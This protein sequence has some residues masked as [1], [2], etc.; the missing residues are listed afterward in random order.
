MLCQVDTPDVTTSLP[1]TLVPPV[2]LARLLGEARVASGESLDDLVR[3]SGLAFEEE[4]FAD[5]ESGRASLDEPLVRWLAELY[6]VQA[7]AIVPA[8]SQLIIDLNEG[9]VAVGDTNVDL[10]DRD[11]AHILTNYLAL[12]YSLRGLPVGTPIPLRQV[13]LSALS[14]AL[15]LAPREVSSALGH[16]MIS[17]TDHVRDHARSLR[18]RLVVPVAGILVGLTAV[19][20]LLLVRSEGA[21][22]AHPVAPSSAST[23]TAAAEIPVQIGEAVVLRR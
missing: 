2:R 20:G 22:S 18:R 16:M 14:E 5:V 3:R 7:G 6:G 15:R 9:H 23:V 11:P 8:R 4:F 19:G 12:V 10:E 21:G 13:D 17:R 1:A